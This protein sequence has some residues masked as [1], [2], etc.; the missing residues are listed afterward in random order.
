MRLPS[1]DLRDYPHGN[2]LHN[3]S[4]N[5]LYANRLD[6]FDVVPTQVVIVGDHLTLQI[7]DNTWRTIPMRAA[8]E[9]YGLTRRA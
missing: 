2:A 6:P 8:P 7:S 4:L 3:G 1:V 9:K 5:W